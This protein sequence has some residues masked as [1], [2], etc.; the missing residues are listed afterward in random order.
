MS[1][2]TI[3]EALDR[4]TDALVAQ[5]DVE[6]KRKLAQD[7][8]I[9]A[10]LTLVSA[11]L[12]RQSDALDEMHSGPTC[13]GCPHAPHPDARCTERVNEGRDQCECDAEAGL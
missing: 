3:A 9:Q 10:A 13:T 12:K 2:R 1:E 11:L 7:L 5:W 8:Q 4:L 6:N